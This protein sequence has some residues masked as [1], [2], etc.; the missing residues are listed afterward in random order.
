MLFLGS[1]Q[2]LNSHIILMLLYVV[3]FHAP[4]SY[5]HVLFLFFKL[6]KPN[7]WFVLF[8][9]Q[10][11]ICLTIILEVSEKSQRRKRASDQTEYVTMYE[12]M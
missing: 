5:E 3:R 9:Q 4:L 8:E 2:S 11:M 7:N 1:K 10:E 6:S 12:T